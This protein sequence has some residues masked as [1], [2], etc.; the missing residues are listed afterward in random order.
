MNIFGVKWLFGLCL[1][2]E[3][4]FDSFKP[5]YQQWLRLHGLY[6]DLGGFVLAYGCC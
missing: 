6:S 3:Y 2:L 4:L 1:D 5:S